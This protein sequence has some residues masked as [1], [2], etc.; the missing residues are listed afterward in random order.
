MSVDN[1]TT[2]E[3]E[4]DDD[5]GISLYDN[6]GYYNAYTD[7][8]TMYNYGTQGRCG[9]AVAAEGTAM[10][11]KGNRLEAAS[12]TKTLQID[13]SMTIH[14]VTLTCDT[15]SYTLPTEGTALLDDGLTSDHEWRL[16]DHTEREGH[17]SF[18]VE[19]DA[20]ITEPN[21]DDI[22]VSTTVTLDE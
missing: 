18:T 13:G 19:V 7:E 8:D 15:C 1:D 6:S 9:V 4:Q 11:T 2:D 12:V 22:D 21:V 16:Q 17:E 20:E 10:E 3:T 14:E 5:K